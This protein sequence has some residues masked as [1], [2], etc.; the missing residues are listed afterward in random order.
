MIFIACT[1]C[2]AALQVVDDI[3]ASDQLVGQQSD[4]WPDKYTCFACGEPA[5]GA[6]TPQVSATIMARAHIVNVTAAEAFAALN[7]LG[8]P[9]ER[10]C[11]EEVVVPY[12]AAQGIKVKGKQLR[13]QLRY[14]VNELVF[15]DGS[16]M[17][18]GVSP[19]GA[20]VYRVAKPHS[21]AKG[22]DDAG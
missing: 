20:V 9:E 13:G 19:Q 22:V 5:V 18:F 17:C 7:G 12:F 16:R 11:C 3:D 8:V 21:Y 2:L 14:V 10:T 15:P 4:F 6:L 1:R